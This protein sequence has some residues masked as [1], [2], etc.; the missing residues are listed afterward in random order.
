M[1][2]EGNPP[3]SVVANTVLNKSLELRLFKRTIGLFTLHLS[4]KD[5]KT[6][7]AGCAKRL[8][9]LLNSEVS[10]PF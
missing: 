3:Q 10:S 6:F 5:L 4:Q 9:H 8:N 2:M 1:Q 7:T